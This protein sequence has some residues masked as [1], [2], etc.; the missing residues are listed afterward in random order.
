VGRMWVGR[1]VGGWVGRWVG[2][3]TSH[4]LHTVLHHSQHVQYSNGNTLPG[5]MQPALR[6]LLY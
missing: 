5:K 3:Y 1:W 2:R 6:R 4:I